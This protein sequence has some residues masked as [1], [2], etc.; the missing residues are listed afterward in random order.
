MKEHQFVGRPLIAQCFRCSGGRGQ[1]DN[2]PLCEVATVTQRLGKLIKQRRFYCQRCLVLWLARQVCRKGLQ[3]PE[4]ATR[5]VQ[6]A[7]HADEESN[8]R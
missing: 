4:W 8:G 2:T 5:L 3:L 7:P 1:C 6:V